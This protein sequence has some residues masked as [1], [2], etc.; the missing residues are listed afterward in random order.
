MPLTPRSEPRRKGS[1]RWFLVFWLV[2]IALRMWSL[3]R[4]LAIGLLA[5]AFVLFLTGLRRTERPYGTPGPTA[6]P[7]PPASSNIESI[8]LPSTPADARPIEPDMGGATGKL[9]VL[10]IVVLGLGIL[11]ALLFRSQGWKLTP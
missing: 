5:V 3:N 9:I 1:P 10:A 11:V 4:G 8:T 2:L 7:M 6:M